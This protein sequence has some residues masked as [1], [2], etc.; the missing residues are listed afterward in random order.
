MFIFAAQ[1]PPMYNFDDRNK[2]VYSTT[3]ID[4]NIPPINSPVYSKNISSSLS[5]F[6]LL[7]WEYSLRKKI[8]KEEALDSLVAMSQKMILSNKT[9][10][11]DIQAVIDKEFWN[12]I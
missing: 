12:L 1:L 6:N 8:T 4:R 7:G 10:D 2:V 3:L 11:A 9:I 5:N